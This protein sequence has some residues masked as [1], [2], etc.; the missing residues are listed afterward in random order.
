MDD[1]ASPAGDTLTGLYR[2][3]SGIAGV[4]GPISAVVV[5]PDGLRLALNATALGRPE[6]YQQSVLIALAGFKGTR[7]E[8][9]LGA[10]PF[11]DSA[12]C[13][14][15]IQIAQQI[16]PARVVVVHAG[17]RVQDI[18][19]HLGMNKVIDITT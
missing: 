1:R 8:I 3:A 10:L 15:M 4:H 6:K 13:S 16:Q 5:P 2:R 11:I 18:L 17:S 7:V 19:R 9:D 14:W 12:F